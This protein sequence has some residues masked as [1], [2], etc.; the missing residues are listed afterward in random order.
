MPECI[1]R[2]YIRNGRLMEVQH[3]DSSFLADPHYIYEVFRV[4]E[5]IPLFLEDHLDRLKKTI[6][7]TG[8]RF[9]W[10]FPEIGA[11]VKDLVLAN[12]M[13]TG[14]IKIVFRPGPSPDLDQLLV[15]IMEHQY[16]NDTQYREGVGVMLF[17]GVRQNPNAKV[18]DVEL[19][20]QTR[21][22]KAGKGMY[23]ALLVDQNGFITE[24]SRS[25]VFFIKANELLTPPLEDVLPG[26]TRKYILQLSRQLKI[27]AIEQ[28]V[29]VEDLE[30][31]DGLFISGTSRK[32][33]PVNQ[34][35]DM[36]FEV[37]HPVTRQLQKAFDKKVAEYLELHKTS[38]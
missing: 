17:Y 21:E 23:E 26:I 25:N 27:P 33:L 35:D 12:G 16:P 6:S 1:G 30:E 4:V 3:F 20:R 29:K 32:V 9:P 36:H 38:A 5:G 10:S 2:F 18:M 28:K 14:N 24:G 34:V 15:Y 31:M 37:E 13:K 7:L 19:R 8:A 11:Q 22:Q